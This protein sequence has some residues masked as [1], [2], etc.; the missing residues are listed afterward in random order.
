MS[1]TEYD[2]LSLVN[3]V[4]EFSKYCSEYKKRHL[5]NSIH[6]CSINN[7]VNKN[8]E[9]V[10]KK[11]LQDF[12]NNVNLLSSNILQ[13]QNI[14][15][16]EIPQNMLYEKNGNKTIYDIKFYNEDKL[17]NENI[18]EDKIEGNNLEQI[19]SINDKEFVKYNDYGENIETIKNI[20]EQNLLMQ[21]KN[22]HI[23]TYE[24]FYMRKISTEYTSSEKS[25]DD[26][27]LIHNIN[28]VLV[29]YVSGLDYTL[30]IRRI[31]R[32]ELIEQINQF[33]IIHNSNIQLND[34]STYLSDEVINILKQKKDNIKY[35]DKNNPFIIEK[36]DDFYKNNFLPF[37]YI[38]CNYLYIRNYCNENERCLETT[39]DTNDEKNSTTGNSYILSSPNQMYN[40]NT[41]SYNSRSNSI[42]ARN[43][44]SN[45]CNSPIFGINERNS[46]PNFG[47]FNESIKNDKD[48]YNMDPN[49]LIMRYNLNEEVDTTNDRPINY[50]DNMK[51]TNDNRYNS[52]NFNIEHIH[53]NINNNTQLNNYDICD[54]NNFSD[55]KNNLNSN[56]SDFYQSISEFYKNNEKNFICQEQNNNNNTY[57]EKSSFFLNSN[58]TNVLTNNKNHH[59]SG[60]NL[61]SL[62]FDDELSS[63]ITINN[64]C[65]LNKGIYNEYNNSEK[66]IVED[67]CYTTNYNDIN[68]DHM[69]TYENDERKWMHEYCNGD[70]NLFRSKQ[71][72]KKKELLLSYIS[73]NEKENKYKDEDNTMINVEIDNDTNRKNILY[74]TDNI[75]FDDNISIHNH[76]N[77]INLKVIYEANKSE[78]GN[79]ERMNFIKGQIILNKYKVVKVLSK[80]QFSTTLKCLNLLYKKVKNNKDV[81]LKNCDKYM[82]DYSDITHDKQNNSDKF[83]NLNIIKEKNED[84][85]RQ[86]EIKNNLHDNN[87]QLINNKKKIEPKYVCLKVMK[88][89]K[90]FLD[91][92]LLELMVLNI[93]CNDNTNNNLSNKNI[94]ELY[95]SFYYKEHLIIVT[96]YMQ[97]DLYNYFIRKG[98][99]GTLGQLQILTKNLLEGLAYI[100]SK[101]LIHCDLKP[102]NIM[103]NMKKNK[104][105][106]KRDKYYKVNENGAT[107][108]NDAMEQNILNSSNINMSNKEENK[109]I[110]YPSFDQSFIENKDTQYD[111]NQKTSNMLCDINKSYNNSVKDI[112][113]NDNINIYST[114]QF[115]K[116][117]IIDFN[118]CIYE[119]DKLEMY[120]Q[121]RSYRSPEVL[122]QQNYDRKI[123]IWSLGCILFEF[124]T[125]KILFDYQNIYRFIYSIVSYIGPFPFYMINN[126]RIPHIFTKHGLIILKKFT[127]DNMYDNYIKEEQLNQV[128]DEEIIFNSK[129]F[130][131]L[132]KKDNIITKDLLKN[133]NPNTSIPRK[134]NNSN[135]EIYYDVCYP[136]DNL[137]KNNFQI[138]DKL[139][140]DFLSSLLQI[141]P[142]KRCN[143]TEALKHPWLQ[144]NLYKDGL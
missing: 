26:N 139:F 94:I 19:K 87:N 44:S 85:N 114:K 4:E 134:R 118:S 34:Y 28:N 100:H 70:Y 77:S 117:K 51:S 86:H 74:D 58:E 22:D 57:I 73:Y 15:K 10:F 107:T 65:S 5:T 99:L 16:C 88:N 135:S 129:D 81:F 17:N 76:Y 46:S 110:T 31:S 29:K 80:T 36:N 35:I 71:L 92:G 38:P 78:Y 89:G 98:K 61:I 14:N 30:N 68:M 91:Q 69:N 75:S 141:D 125:K 13:N 32:K 84:Y 1:K 9:V 96:E 8:E 137:L 121:T 122:L 95:D 113:N 105:N 93:L 103:I 136:S 115:D 111:D 142:S 127:T 54:I 50:S 7:E 49:Y 23:N 130:F 48:Q 25:S 42:I 108:Y 104:K 2:I 33:Y 140:L 45:K 124:L 40:T 43:T 97:S 132:N 119:S 67:I 39:Y 24:N 144:P 102:E 123:D 83:V 138:S 116:I 128:D 27:I 20:N 59:S 72:K 143:A 101:N 106:H 60:K 56:T 64:D 12:M 79:N 133:K 131:R 90:Q 52:P 62:C 37:F 47:I 41:N 6:S 66:A 21:N 120:V 112:D 11:T 109:I 82:K 3:V 55:K 63:A 53:N 18:F 126:C